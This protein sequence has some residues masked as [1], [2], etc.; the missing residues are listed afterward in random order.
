MSKLVT[1]LTLAKNPLDPKA[2]VEVLARG[3]CNKLQFRKDL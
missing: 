3:S 1:G 2:R